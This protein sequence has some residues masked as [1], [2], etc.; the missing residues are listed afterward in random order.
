MILVG[1]MRD[2]ET[3]AT[4][5]TA[6]ETGHLVFATLHT[7]SA[8]TRRSTASSTSSPPSSRARCACSSRRR[9]QGVVTQTLVPTADGRGRVAA[10]EILMPDDAVR[11]LI[12][13]AKVE[14][15]YSV[16][17]TS[18]SRGHADD[19]AVARRPRAARRHHARARVR[20]LVPTRSASGPA[21]A[22]GHDELSPHRPP[23]TA[24]P[25]AT[26]PS[27]ERA[28][29]RQGGIETRGLEQGDQAVGPR[30]A[31]EEEEGARRRQAEQRKRKR[32]RKQEIVG[33]K[34]GASQIA[35]SRVVNN[36][37][38]K[39][40]QLARASLEPGVVVGGE[41]RDVAALATALDEL[42]QRQQASAPGHPARHRHQ[43]HRRA[44]RRHRR[45]RRRAPARQRRSLQG[46]RGSLDPARPGRPRLPRR[47][48]D[49]RRVRRPSHRRVLLA[50]A[51]KEPIDHYVE[52]CRR[53]RPRALGHRRRGVRAAA[54]RR[55]AYGRRRTRTGGRSVVVS[56]GHDRSTLA[57]SDGTV[58]D[59]MRV[60][61]WGGSK[62][63]SAIAQELGLTGPEA[64][65]LKLEL[66][67]AGDAPDGDDPRAPL[68]PAPRSNVSCRRLRA[69]WSPLSTSTRASPAHSP[70]PRSSSP[71]VRRGFRDWPR[72]SSG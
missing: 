57:I 7:Q 31:A 9:S 10:L 52:A 49:G 35:A 48:R 22:L 53:G 2:L 6:A 50:A 63:E 71:A 60:L 55:A 64:A 29:A 46:A 39:L 58:C 62:L 18:T 21:R 65:E 12:R 68:A 67:L 70:S 1:E 66:D 26:D 34:I 45:R 72:S 47:Q 44:H 33:L 51:Y 37:S 28:S 11:N 13:Q 14:Q 61:D 25:P 8:P 43:P 38:A 27:R 30:P 40:V 54:R 5:L 32:R 24:A 4:A 16:M 19:G 23:A 41:V 36:G 20:A 69:S 42:L 56:I 59:F 15:I 17:Q 3:I